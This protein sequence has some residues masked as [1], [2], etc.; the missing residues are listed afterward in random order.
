MARVVDPTLADIRWERRRAHWRGYGSLASALA[1]HVIS[2]IPA[3]VAAVWLEDG[4]AMPRVTILSIGAAAIGAAP[5]V[6]LPLSQVIHDAGASRG[7]LVLTLVPQALVLTLPTGLLVAV[8][9]AIAKTEP[10]ARLIRRVILLSAL[11]AGATF[12]LIGWIMPV[13]NQAYRVAT[14]GVSELERGPNE[15][16]FRHIK[17]EIERLRTFHGSETVIRRMEYGCEL[18]LSLAAAAVRLGLV[19]LACAFSPLGRRRPFLTGLSAL[20]L[21]FVGIFSFERLVVE[22]VLRGTSLPA[23]SLAWVPNAFIVLIAGVLASIAVRPSAN[24]Q[25][26]IANQQ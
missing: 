26:P 22:S 13:A 3:R 8:P 7:W 10:S 4:H 6:A 16:P 17:K 1:L 11:Y 9:V 19:A 2:S 23:G 5:L 21:Y 25:S 12:G 18:R 14:S 15:T 24:R 20:G